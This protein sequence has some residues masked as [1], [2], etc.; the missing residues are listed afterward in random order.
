MYSTFFNIKFGIARHKEFLIN[1]KINFGNQIA[2]RIMR[3]TCS[4]FEI[5]IITLS[6][7]MS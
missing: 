2:N 6:K 5:D 7:V 3:K 1:S 4:E